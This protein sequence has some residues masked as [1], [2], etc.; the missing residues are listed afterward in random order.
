M[1]D[2]RE[3]HC[4]DERAAI[5]FNRKGPTTMVKARAKS[6]VEEYQIRLNGG[7]AF[8]PSEI[9]CNTIKCNI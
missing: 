4:R 9:K 7:N 5:T 3:S 2:E 8:L 6:E 1:R